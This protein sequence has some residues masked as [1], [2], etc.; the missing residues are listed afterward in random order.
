MSNL[1]TVAD[2]CTSIAR[3]S[4]TLAAL[5]FLAYLVTVVIAVA[6]TWFPSLLISRKSAAPTSADTPTGNLISSQV[7]DATT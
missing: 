2:T 5:L 1:P 3:A 6:A 7:T 4:L